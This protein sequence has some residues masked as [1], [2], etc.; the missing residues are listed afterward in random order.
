MRLLI[1]S[2]KHETN[3]FSPVPT[4]LARFQQRTLC[5][6]ADVRSTFAGTRTGVG[7]Y[8]RL[9]EEVHA[10]VVTP[11]AAEA[12]PSGPVHTDAYD[13]ITDAIC[14]AV[15]GRIDGIML[16]LHGAM[17]AESTR[18]GEGRLLERIRAIAPNMPI[19]VNLD[20]HANLTQTMMDH[21][22]AMIG[23]KTY[24]HIDSFETA[25][26]IGRV[27]L[28]AMRGEVNPVMAWDNRP[29]LAQTLRMGHED[30][31]MASLLAMTRETEADGILAA[32]VFGG[33]PL[34]DFHDAGLSAVVV[35]D[36]DRKHAESATKRLLDAAWHLRVDFIYEGEPLH[37]AIARAKQLTEG[38]V[39]LLDHADN[40]ASG[41]TQDVM[42]VIAEVLSQGLED[43][44]V[45]SVK[46][47]E[48]VQAMIRAGV[49]AEVTLELGGK[50]D[51]PAIG[52][53]GESLRVTGRVRCITDGD[54][55]VTGPMNTGVTAHM[56][57]T[58]VLDTGAVQIVVCSFNNEPFD[59]GVFTSVGID[60]KAKRYLVLKSR[61]HY[62][63]GFQPIARHT[64]TCDGIGV[65]S[66][67]NSLFEYRHVRRPIYPLDADV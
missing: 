8:L 51:M 32:T 67:D 49:G 22:T 45:A 66:S 16:D 62:R 11:V 26:Q 55:R 14:E 5:F 41:G 28:A 13:T 52:R 23:Y 18:D 63:A 54:F 19:C 2:M 12:A 38:P 61:I 31:P 40:A 57:P 3:T 36:G 33:F 20:L 35:A 65:C 15:D 34:A 1:A 58:A 9:A 48:A 56:G 42:S 46:D 47:P 24:P 30:E 10:E 50:T 27:L 25:I 6:G 64:I 59:Q 7:A 44:A 43:V 29:L 4:D 60:P 39:I 17:V 21:C 53:K 37:E